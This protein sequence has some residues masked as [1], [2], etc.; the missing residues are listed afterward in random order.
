M[1][2]NS[3]IHALLAI[4]GEG[5]QFLAFRPN[6]GEEPDIAALLLPV[7]KRNRHLRRPHEF[8]PLLGI[9][10]G[11]PIELIDSIA[12]LPKSQ[13][14]NTRYYSIEF[15][16]FPTL[17]VYPT[18]DNPKPIY[19][20][21]LI[22]FIHEH[23]PELSPTLKVARARSRKEQHER[24][25]ERQRERRRKAA[26]YPELLPL[27]KK[28]VAAAKLRKEQPPEDLHRH[29]PKPD[30]KT[31]AFIRQTDRE[32]ELIGIHPENRSRKPPKPR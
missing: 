22:G 6:K 14:V 15:N 16:P 17:Q 1:D 12:Q 7:I 11:P 25:M 5:L 19:Q 26:L 23:I 24:Q 29:I 10:D 20:G 21:G 18:I 28:I 13:R 3:P 30:A 27:N 32:R 31:R 9:Y 4:Q 8:V 2:K